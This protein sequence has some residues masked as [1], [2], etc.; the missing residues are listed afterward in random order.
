MQGVQPYDLWSSS[1]HPED[2]A[3][4]EQSLQ[5][6]LA[7]RARFVTEYRIVWPGGE[8]RHI[9]GSAAVIR[10]ANGLGMTMHGVNLDI[11]ERKRADEKL[12]ALNA[13]LEQRVRARTS[14]LRERD[15]LIQEIHHRVKN[16]LQVISS[17]IN[18]QIRGLEGESSRAALRDCQARV[19]TMA[20]IHEMLYQSADYA[21]VPFGKYAQE[22][23]T[24]ILRASGDSAGNVTLDFDLQDV[25]LPVEQAIPCGLILNELVANCLKHAFPNGACGRIR[26]ELRPAPDRSLSLCVSDNGVGIPAEL[27]WENPSSLGLQLVM[28]LT[29]QLDGRLEIIRLPGSTFRITFPLGSHT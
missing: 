25:S 14:E 20:Q 2:R 13:E 12:Q 11:T 8:T 17:L 3:A 16:N 15:S 21:Q 5:D 28:T 26:V 6:A 19:V 29:E 27:N 24:R 4:T 23:T 1:L 22:L 10:D 9:R 18:M 7:G